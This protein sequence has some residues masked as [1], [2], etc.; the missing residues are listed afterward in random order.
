M[1]IYK[2]MSMSSLSL[3][4]IWLAV[5]ICTFLALICAGAPFFGWSY[6]SMEGSLTS[7][8]VEWADRSFSVVSY[9]IF[10]FIITYVAP[11]LIISITNFKLLFIVII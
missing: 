6:Y 8:S 2:P 5:G 3:K 7:C 1:I 4:K 10:I 9:N 11:V